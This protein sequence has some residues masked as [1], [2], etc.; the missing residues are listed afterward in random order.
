MKQKEA[1]NVD[2]DV[3]ITSVGFG[4][5]E[6]SGK[7]GKIKRV[8][9]KDKGPDEYAVL[10]N[11]S[12]IEFPEY[13]LKKKNESFETTESII[14][15]KECRIPGT[16]IILEEGDMIRI[17]G[18]AKKHENLDDGWD[19][20]LN[21]VHSSNAYKAYSKEFQKY[22]YKLFTLKQNN[23]IEANVTELDD[24]KND[25]HPQ[26]YYSGFDK[27]VLVQTSSYGALDVNQHQLFI[28]HIIEGNEA[29]KLL[30]KLMND[31][32]FWNSIPDISEI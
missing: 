12:E 10:I 4:N 2:D 23:R 9:K 17:Y 5:N 21:A 13:R 22:G 15:K 19:R 25:F 32:T 30:A 18:L 29:A 28:K 6:F 20:Y 31:R 7:H 8:I 26:V 1:F 11:G 16:D 14:I 3:V 27:K 24:S